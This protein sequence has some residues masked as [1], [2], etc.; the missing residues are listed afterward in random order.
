[1][2]LYR[3]TWRLL[4]ESGNLRDYWQAMFG[5]QLDAYKLMITP[6]RRMPVGIRSRS[7]GLSSAILKVE[8]AFLRSYRQ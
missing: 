4:L 1:M 6:R 5:Y 8:R 7:V 2:P 3:A